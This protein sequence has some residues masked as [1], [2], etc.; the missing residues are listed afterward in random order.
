MRFSPSQRSD[1]EA[2]D[3][4]PPRRQ[5]R[6]RQPWLQ[7]LIPNVPRRG[8]QDVEKAMGSMRLLVVAD[9]GAAATL[10]AEW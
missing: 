1:F 3:S 10:T 2:A 6:Q 8:R 7:W 5:Q 9:A 4:P